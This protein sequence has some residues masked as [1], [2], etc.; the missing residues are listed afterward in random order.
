M[1][2]IHDALCSK[3]HPAM[4]H[5]LTYKQDI[6]YTINNTINTIQQCF[7]ILDKKRILIILLISCICIIQD[8]DCIYL[9]YLKRNV[10]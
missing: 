7:T 1:S 10:Q 2:L 9:L 4:F 8:C 5:N 3:R 6:N